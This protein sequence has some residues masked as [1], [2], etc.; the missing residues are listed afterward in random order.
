MKRHVLIIPI[1]L[2][3]LFLG[4]SFLQYHSYRQR[5]TE[6][7]S[8]SLERSVEKL[9]ALVQTHLNSHL[10]FLDQLVETLAINSE[11]PVVF[12]KHQRSETLGFWVLN[13]N[14]T[15]HPQSSDQD[16]ALAEN[17][18]EPF[19][20]M[21]KQC[22]GNPEARLFIPSV[23]SHEFQPLYLMKFMPGRDEVLVTSFD[24][25]Q[26]LKTAITSN[27]SDPLSFQVFLNDQ[28]FWK[29]GQN[30]YRLMAER[31]FTWLNTSFRIISFPGNFLWKDMVH[32]SPKKMLLM[33]LTLGLG[34][35]I[36]VG[37]F[38]WLNQKK[39]D[40]ES[41]Y[42]ILFEQA[43]EG[44]F[45]IDKQH[46]VKCNRKFIDLFGLQLY[47]F[48]GNKFPD[49]LE[50]LNF[51]LNTEEL[52]V[53]FSEQGPQR[54]EVE[55]KRT[56]G[57]D[58]T[59]R[60][61]VNHIQIADH[62]MILG[63][64]NDI[65][66]QKAQEKQL[67][68]SE[69]G[70]R[71]LIEHAPELIFLTQDG[72]IKMPNQQAFKITG[73]EKSELEH[74]IFESFIHEEDQDTFRLEMRKLASKPDKTTNFSARML[75]K[76]Q[77]VIWLD[78][79]AHEFLWEEK[80]AVLNFIRN[81]S[82]EKS[83]EGQLFQAQKM[84]A[85]GTLAAGIAHDFNNL[86]QAI[87]GNI[88][89]TLN[90]NRRN[91]SLVESLMNMEAH[92][93]RGSELTS[94]LLGFAKGGQYNVKSVLISEIVERTAVMFARTRK[95]LKMN[96]Q[97][98]KALW[99]VDVDEGQIE[100]VLINL[101]MNAWQAMPDGGVVTLRTEKITPK[102]LFLE[103]F[104]LENGNYVKISVVDTGIGMS[105][106]TQARVFEPFFTLRPKKMGTG[107][108]LASAYGIIKNH[109]GAIEI[110]SALGEGSTFNIYLPI[111]S[112]PYQK[113]E[114]TSGK[115]FFG[116]ETIMVVDDEE[117]VLQMTSEMLEALGY[118]VLQAYSGQDALDLYHS[119]Q[120]AI[121]LVVLDMIMPGMNGDAVFKAMRA[122]APKQK[123]LLCSGYSMDQVAKTLMTMGA[124]GF[125]GKPFDIKA[126]S[127]R[128]K[129]ALHPELFARKS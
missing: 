89:I 17:D 108:G 120:G 81:I 74:Q 106:E 113:L 64:V 111:S 32:S 39:R 26:L 79:H 73:Y 85:I 121:D 37:S 125:L 47:Q 83:L 18:T 93:K 68:D 91:S 52:Q 128:V 127:A 54:F 75:N 114:D 104:G 66:Q 116:S 101:F 58:Q 25:A 90:K 13:L 35:S 109:K 3:I 41:K 118:K 4:F 86:L 33:A 29:S 27:L 94:Q 129:E 44:Y 56:I 9:P 31:S 50:Q 65:S 40:A 15:I 60:F 53:L 96:Y 92:V 107:L 110:K 36:L 1:S 77:E 38:L 43:N 80:P 22:Y 49:A 117:Q 87:M 12:L 82:Q 7:L 112:K 119:F 6:K 8:I 67:R 70:Y 69:K 23:S 115:I 76:D 99:T 102:P 97:F 105:Q 28:L 55:R 5:E 72:Q 2:L 48:E 78:I 95:E 59:L 62:K 21:V 122:E 16:L 42:R 20:A 10:E 103:T 14:R 88:S 123:I 19:W 98:Q 30:L 24:G 57:G 45:L 100:Q 124:N 11:K 51:S 126:L 71:R 34:F 61:H 46:F 63:I 84:E